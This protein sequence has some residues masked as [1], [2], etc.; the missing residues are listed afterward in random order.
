MNIFNDLKDK[1]NAILQKHSG[2]VD[3]ALYRAVTVELPKD[4]TH[5]DMATNAAMVFAKPLGQPPRVIAEVIKAG[6]EAL[7]EVAMV[8]IAGPGFVNITLH[9]DFWQR[10]I[11]SILEAGE[12]YGLS[13]MGNGE[14]VNVEYVSANPTGPLHIG[15][16]RGA[17]V[18][19]ALALLL[20]KAG[21]S[22]TREYYIN[23]AGAQTDVLARSAFLRYREALGQSIGEIPAGLYPG[24]YLVA[25]GEALAARDGDRWLEASEA[26][27]LA[28][29]RLFAIDAMMALIRTD[30]ADL[31][32]Y[33]DVFTSERLLHDENRIA[34]VLAELEA[35]GTL[36]RGVLEPPKGKTP[37][38]WE[39]REQLLFRTTEYG[40]DCDRPLAK[41]DGSYTYFAADAAYT[42]DKLKRHFKSLVMVLGA[43]HGGYI[44]RMK[45]LVKVLSEDKAQLDILLCQLVK[46]YE[47]GQPFKM[48]KRAGT[49][50]TVRDVLEVVGKDVLRFVMLMRKP[51]Q[52]LDF[53][54]VKVKEQ[55]KDNPVFYV[56]YAH[57]RCQSVL[58]QPHAA[59][60]SERSQHADSALLSR[61]SH[62][63][64]LAMIRRLSY[65]PRL[66]ESAALSREPHRVAYYLYDVAS[67]LHGLWTLGNDDPSL[68]FIVESDMEVSAARLT[69]LRAV[70][71]VL[72]SGMHVLG[73]EPLHEMR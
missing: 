46:L 53:D 72:A 25:V 22:V 37:D 57:A 68:R 23:D 33:H 31:G 34:E 4:A 14:A 43:D 30:L 15:H 73:V 67:D 71:T 60:A 18:G 55:S 24:D 62:P 38:D 51:E 65:W 12:S 11:L 28:P 56:N 10:Q 47:G 1:V 9:A 58:R 61:L 21:Y 6:L 42:R 5:G 19:D 69:L 8:E 17:V 40:D 36:Y 7:P 41:S 27:W 54:L 70:A 3:A 49:F 35:K 26:E 2:L 48:S 50:V 32:I 13:A 66:V 63:A 45:A 59:E 64:E 44:N 20:K 29:V 39:A 16:A 52:A